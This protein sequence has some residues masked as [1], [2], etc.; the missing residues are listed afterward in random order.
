M[1]HGRIKKV[2][3]S[4]IALL[5]INANAKEFPAVPGEY[6]VKLKNTTSVMSSLN[7]E[8]ELGGEIKRSISKGLGLVLVARSTVET[9]ASA[10]ERL[11]Q[12]A[13]VEYAEPNYI[14]RVNGG[15]PTLPTDPEFGKLWGM[16]NTGQAV[17]G[18]AGSFQAVAGIDIDA[19][20]AWQIETGSKE[21]IVAVIDTGVNYKDPDLADNIYTN[22]V[23]LNGKPGVD[24]DANGCIDDIHGCNIVGKNGD[25]MDVFGHGTHVSGTIGA[26]ANDGV[27]V[28]G[29]AWNVSILP[30][31]FLG[32]DGSGTLA[33]AITGIEYAITMKA[34]IMSNSWGGGAFSQALLDVISKAKNAGILFVAAAGNESNDNDQSPS[35]PASYQLDNVISVAAIDPTGQVASF[36][37]FGKTSV[38]VAAP[39]VD[40]LSHTMKGLESWSG[41]SM[42][43]PHVSGIAA[44]LLAQDKTQSYSTIKQ[45]IINSARPLA[46]LRGRVASAGIANAYF[47]LTNQVAPPDGND[48][49]NW[50]KDAQ[51]AMTPHPYADNAKATWTFKVSG[52]KQIA[53][54][55]SK[56]MTEANYDKVE[57]KDS[58]GKTAGV[59]SGKLGDTFGPVVDGDTVTITFTADGS[60]SDYGFDVGGI[61]Y[62]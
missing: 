30:V 23:E 58:T 62:R 52:A 43:T 60:N 33:D 45:R 56:F 36:S 51:S 10:L 2:A 53:V 5:T 44:L 40:I 29:V 20:R 3:L 31:R 15:S 18:D 61:A 49:F 42:A 35:Y 11:Q 34:N 27:G 26:K 14:Y 7:L 16:V 4:L 13:L 21:I 1:T 8:R 22:V 19:A 17:T 57:F 28:V 32:D 47:A 39:G 38:H 50:Q 46:G 12:N 25:P 37:N 24:D 48:P 41:T 55:F 9:K 54:Y 59:L 6:V